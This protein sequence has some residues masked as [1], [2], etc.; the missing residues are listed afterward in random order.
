MRY[1]LFTFALIIKSLLTITLSQGI[2]SGFITDNGTGEPVQGV[3]V[4]S[5]GNHGTITGEDGF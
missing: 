1:Y 3:Y 5:T 2:V 4:I